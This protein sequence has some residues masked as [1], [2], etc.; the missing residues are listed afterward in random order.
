MS[1]ILN[2]EEMVKV[3]ILGQG[4][5]SG[6]GNYSNN[7][8]VTLKA[9]PAQGYEFKGWSGDL[10]GS[11][12]PLT[13]T[14]SSSIKANAHF[15]AVSSEIVLI[16]GY[17]AL[18]GSFTAKLNET[19]RR[20][21]KRRVNRVGDTLVYRRNKVLDDLVSIEWDSEVKLQD[22]LSGKNLSA[23]EIQ[24]LSEKRSALKSRGVEKQ[25]KEMINS[26][27]YE[28]V[29]PNWVLQVGSVPND[30]KYT[31]GYLWGLKKSN[32]TVG[33][34]GAN[35]EEA[36]QITTGSKEIK[37]AVIDSGIRYTHQDLKVNMWNNPDEIAGNGK[38]DDG[39]G[40]IDDIYGINAMRKIK[41]SK[42]GDPMDDNG[43]GTHV[44]GTIG[45]QANGGGE[46]VGVAWDV[47]LIALK[48]LGHDGRGNTSDAIACIDYAIAKGAKVINASYGGGGPSK[49][50]RNAIKR[51]RDAGV[52]FVAAAGN[53][54]SN[55]DEKP[56]YPANYKVNNV[57]SVASIYFNG[58][59]SS[60]SNYGLKSVDIGAPGSLIYSTYHSNDTSYQILSGTSMAAPHVSGVAALILSKEPTLTPSQLRKRLMD[61][62]QPLASLKNKTVSGGALDAYAAL[63]AAPKQYLSLDVEHD[64]DIPEKNGKLTVTARVTSPQPVTGASVVAT[65]GRGN[66]NLLDNGLGVDEKAN[67]GIYSQSVFAPN[68]L[69]FDLAVQAKASGYEDANKSIPVRTIDRP[70]N[71][72]FA[73]AIPLQGS[74]SV[75]VGNNELAT[76]ESGEP[77]FT[78]GMNGTLWYSWRPSRS[79]DAT[80]STFGSSFDTTLAI[81]QG[82]NLN[83]L[84]LVGSNDDHDERQFASEVKF[85]AVQNKV[86]WLQIAGI[87]N[88]SGEFKINHPQ[89][90]PP[91]PPKPKIDP[92]IILSKAADLT[93]TE[94]ESMEI[95]VLAVGTPPLTYQ[96]VVNGGKIFGADESSFS[97]PLLSTEN[98]GQY[99]V[100]VQNRGG[101][102][103]AD[104]ANVNVRE[105][106]NPPLND[107][108]ENAAVL[109]GDRDRAIAIN[110]IATGQT[111]EP[112]HAGSSSPI[113]SVWW[114]WTAPKDGPVTVD[115]QG[116][117]FDT[118]LAAYQVSET[119]QNDQRRSLAIGRKIPSFTPATRT[120]DIEITLS[121]HGFSNGQIIDIF[122]LSTAPGSARFMVC[123]SNK[124]SFSLSGTAGK[125][126]LFPLPDARV[127]TVK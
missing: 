81:Y 24:E 61:T 37:V 44:A 48:F 32:K 6:T 46:V 42:K 83:G 28:F 57:L 64:P 121:N 111:N 47:K 80:L 87:R 101:T 75:T 104:M 102:A 67:D 31:N 36:W 95:S 126:N 123:D 9:T 33:M 38:D 27:N 116:S 125:T 69:S 84:N 113:N 120:K 49:A 89:P 96:W 25:Y 12:N 54:S 70:S 58:D 71:D 124:N 16:D 56:Q 52:L 13:F 74:K 41:A 68:L 108:I 99:S 107:D 51:A 60:F 98:S 105:S 20:L 119:A 106:Q 85:S 15:E 53:D 117:T 115:T 3:S 77:Q 5:V 78:R 109:E 73:S 26:G 94:G 93:K 34:I 91:T 122:G 55:N 92:P 88:G 14:F 23:R 1:S 127:I 72:S 11:Q 90:T 19:G 59:L 65:L 22:N 21:L 118:T 39:N 17:P 62:T 63:L 8:S 50:T 4:E 114:K 97:I 86:Y 100:I 103:S 10:A 45:A 40:Y 30:A 110:R 18:A 43:H 2:G 35:L 29:E 82:D 66:Y 79:G 7:Q 76:I 112:D